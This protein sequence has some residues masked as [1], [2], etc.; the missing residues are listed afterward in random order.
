MKPREMAFAGCRLLAIYWVLSALNIFWNNASILLSSGNSG[1]EGPGGLFETL[2]MGILIFVL[3][4]AVAAVLWFWAPSLARAIAG[5]AHPGS[6]S[7]DDRVEV[8]WQETLFSAA[9]LFIAVTAI[10][11]IGHVAYQIAGIEGRPAYEPQLTSLRGQMLLK[12]TQL[13]IGLALFFGGR[14]LSGLLNKIRHA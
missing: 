9:G 4:L 7:S 1:I 2:G 6:K 3:N 8:A 14:G 10:P 5:A 13:A 11:E 12:A